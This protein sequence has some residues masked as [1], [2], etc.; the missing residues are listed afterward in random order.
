MTA[1]GLSRL[2]SRSPTVCGAGETI[3]TSRR[4]SRLGGPQP[5]APIAQW[6]CP[7]ATAGQIFRARRKESGAGR[8]LDV[9]GMLIDARI[10][11]SD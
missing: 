10:M 3:K 1:I 2:L 7:S 6:W 5:L 11:L 4:E 8:L 9:V